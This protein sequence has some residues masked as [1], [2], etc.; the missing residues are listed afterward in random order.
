M[1]LNDAITTAAACRYF[2]TEPVPDEVLLRCLDAARFAPQGGNR[3][4]VRFLVVKDEAARAALGKLY[5]TRW[6]EFSGI[7]SDTDR[8]QLPKIA[9]DGDHMARTFGQAPVIVV[10]CVR[11]ADLAITDLGLDRPSVVGGASVYPAVQ[12]FLLS[13]RDAGLGAT[14]TTLLCQDEPAVRGLLAIPDEHL[15]ACHIPVGYR[16]T[17]YPKSLKRRPLSESVS[18]DSFNRPFPGA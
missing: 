11:F 16:A 17:P 14:L 8:N 18:L 13:C 9:L 1:E 7:G 5:L 2:S 3:Q 10:V 6:R 12:N 4:P 15:T